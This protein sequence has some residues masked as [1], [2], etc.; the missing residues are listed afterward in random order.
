VLEIMDNMDI[1]RMA[2]IA[3]RIVS[4]TGYDKLAGLKKKLDVAQGTYTEGDYL[5]AYHQIDNAGER[6][7]G[8][9]LKRGFTALLLARCLQL[10]EWFPQDLRTDLVS[11]EFIYIASLLLK[12]IQSCSCNAYE[13]SELAVKGGSMIN[14]ESLELGGAV[15]PTISLSNHAC[16]G[17]TSRT[18]YGTWCALRAIKTIFPNEK[19]FDNYGHFYHTTSKE[20]RQ[21][22]LQNQYFFKCNCTACK[23]NWPTYRIFGG[24]PTTYQCPACKTKLGQSI[25]KMKKCSNNG[26]KKDLK[27]VSKLNQYLDKLQKEF[28][29]I[30]DGITEENAENYIKTYSKL[31]VEV[32]KVFP[33]PSRQITECQQVLLQ[34]Y[35]VLGNHSTIQPT[36]QECQVAVYNQ[37]AASESEEESDDDDCPGLI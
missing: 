19:V 36:P 31:L 20:E 14:G 5:S 13:I 10:S 15:Y 9:H 17:N 33:Q 35:A 28:R 34:C 8:D 23:Q 27:G 21:H 29:Q 3:Y 25:Q 30:I 7:T 11:E 6:P 1:G 32:E 22:I 4:R 24:A 16:A 12:H 37:G 26:C 18:N 2:T